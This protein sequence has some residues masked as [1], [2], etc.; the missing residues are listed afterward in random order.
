MQSGEIPGG[1]LMP[2]ER[3]VADIPAKGDSTDLRRYGLA[4]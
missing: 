4:R 2:Y 1:A 3:T